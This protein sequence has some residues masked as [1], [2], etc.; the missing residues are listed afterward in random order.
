MPKVNLDDQQ[1]VIFYILTKA[2]LEDAVESG[3]ARALAALEEKYRKERRLKT[4]EAAKFL[5]CSTYHLQD[6]HKQGLPYEKGR[7]NFYRLGDL[8]ALQ[9]SRRLG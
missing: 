4:A 1:P 5:G 3:C 2:Q 7:P 6:L 8:E 9:R